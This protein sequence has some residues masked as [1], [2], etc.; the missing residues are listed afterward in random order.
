MRLSGLPDSVPS[1]SFFSAGVAGNSAI[2]GMPSFAAGATCAANRS[3]VT[4]CTPG[5]DP[6]SVTV[7]L[8]SI[9]NTG[10]IR[11]STLSRFSATSRRVQASWRLRRM[12]TVGKRPSVIVG[13]LLAFMV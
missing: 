3:T 12:R 4:R 11:S 1:A 9:T 2:A 10:Q 8:P 13:M 6:T 7:L 5:I